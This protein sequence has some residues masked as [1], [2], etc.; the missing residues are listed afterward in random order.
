M[1]MIGHHVIS[2]VQPAMADAV[3]ANFRRQFFTPKVIKN[4]W[5]ITVLL[6]APHSRHE[7][8]NT[9]VSVKKIKTWGNGLTAAPA[10]VRRLTP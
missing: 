8:Q 1:A 6:I 4:P 7:G 10:P 2:S 9:R 5:V 3:A